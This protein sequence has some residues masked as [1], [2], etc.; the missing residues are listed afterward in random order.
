MYTFSQSP[1]LAYTSFQD[2][3]NYYKKRYEKALKVID[4]KNN[5]YFDIFQEI[6]LRYRISG[7]ILTLKNEFENAQ[8]TEVSFYKHML[9]LLFK[10]CNYKINI[11][12]LKK[13]PNEYND[14]FATTKKLT[15]DLTIKFKNPP[16]KTALFMD[17]MQTIEYA[18]RYLFI[19]REL[20]YIQVYLKKNSVKDLVE[21][22]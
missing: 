15:T 9:D 7:F 20:Q 3:H 22:K 1:E 12:F 2:I 11:K 21:T 16:E 18:T 10:M 17:F 19:L 6:E 5:I 13:L 8:N 14:L 4:N